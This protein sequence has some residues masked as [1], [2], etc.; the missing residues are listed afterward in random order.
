MH[1]SLQW[2]NLLNGSQLGDDG[3]EKLCNYLASDDC[4]IIKIELEHCGI[5]SVGLKSV[6]NLLKI[7]SRLLYINLRKNSF[8]PEDIKT[9]LLNIKQNKF[10]EY[11]ILD[12]QFLKNPEINYILQSING[13]R[14]NKKANLLLLTHD[15]LNKYNTHYH[16][17]MYVSVAM[18]TLQY[19]LHVIFQKNSQT[20]KNGAASKIPRMKK[21]VKS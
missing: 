17:P 18:C 20:V 10:L 3:I 1:P 6:T 11:L 4:N 12:E 8:S 15:C 5:G 19:I 13:M 7:N 14:R 2:I 9:L 16:T 21:D